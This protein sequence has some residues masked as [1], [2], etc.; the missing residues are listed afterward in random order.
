MCM[1]VCT[2]SLLKLVLNA[3]D[4]ECLPNSMRWARGEAKILDNPSALISLLVRA[5]KE[6]S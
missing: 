2:E 4:G 3:E 5:E 1:H 6:V